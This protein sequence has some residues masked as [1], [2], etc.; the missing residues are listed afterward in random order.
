M[1]KIWK[2][3]KYLNNDNKKKTC[4][5]WDS[6]FILPFSSSFPVQRQNSPKRVCPNPN[7]SLI[8]LAI[9]DDLCESLTWNFRQITNNLNGLLISPVSDLSILWI[10][11][12]FHKLIDNSSQMNS[13]VVLI[14]T[15]FQV[16]QGFFQWPTMTAIFKIRS[17][18]VET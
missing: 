3:M 2:Q 1:G 17:K 8:A 15:I 16:R 9:T 11:T 5:T 10:C 12:S 7:P 14:E 4:G 6:I 18:T 13:S